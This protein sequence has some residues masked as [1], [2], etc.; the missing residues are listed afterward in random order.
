MYIERVDWHLLSLLSKI[1]HIL[2]GLPSPSLLY[3]KH[4]KQQV[5]QRTK[6]YQLSLDCF[7][8]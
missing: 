8:K 1:L 6:K 2:V 3:Q 4:L 7:K 5:G